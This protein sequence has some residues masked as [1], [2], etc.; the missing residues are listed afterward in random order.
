MT[1]YYI[2]LNYNHLLEHPGYLLSSKDCLPVMH[3]KNVLGKSIYLGSRDNTALLNGLPGVLA[4]WLSFFGFLSLGNST[5][6]ANCNQDM[7]APGG[8]IS[9]LFSK[10]FTAPE[11]Q[12]TPHAC[13]RT[14]LRALL[15]TKL[16]CKFMTV[17]L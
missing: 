15:N 2:T 12:Q 1:L 16:C 10:S 6:F 8:T 11:L 4:A 3:R 7:L 13:Q 17:A 5:P 9:A 14:V